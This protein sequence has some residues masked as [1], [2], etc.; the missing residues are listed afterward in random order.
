MTLL[1][2]HHAFEKTGVLDDPLSKISYKNKI[3]ILI[4]YFLFCRY[5]AMKRK[6]LFCCLVQFSVTT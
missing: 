6:L 3:N 2:K 1:S 5:R 4:P